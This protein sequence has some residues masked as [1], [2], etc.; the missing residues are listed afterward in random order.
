MLTHPGVDKGAAYS[1]PAPGG[2]L[3]IVVR[4]AED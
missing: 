1:A 4:L 3:H 2:A